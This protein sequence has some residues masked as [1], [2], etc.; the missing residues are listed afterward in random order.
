MTQIKSVIHASFPGAMPLID[1][2]EKSLLQEEPQAIAIASAFVSLPGF[3]EI[4]KIISLQSLKMKRII[5]GLSNGISHPTAIQMAIDTGWEVRLGKTPPKGI[6]HPKFILCGRSFKRSGEVNMPTFCYVGSSNLTNGGLRRNIE[7][8]QL[9][10]GA[11]ILPTATTAWSSIWK[12]ST[13]ANTSLLK[14]YSEYFSKRNR[15]RSLEDLEDLDLSHDSKF[16]IKNRIKTEKTKTK[17]STPSFS[18]S[19]ANVAWVGLNSFTGEYQFQVEFPRIVAEVA[20]RLIRGSSANKL[21]VHCPAD[22][23]IREMSYR[24]YED[25]GM[26]RLNIPND[27]PGVTQAR[28]KKSG[29]A[30]LERHERKSAQLSLWIIPPGAEADRIMKR[31]SMLGTW[32]STSTRYYGWY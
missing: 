11:T 31:S 5:I 23:V 1:L 27:V 6:F 2:L 14:K 30:V 24:F 28:D 3:E 13:P 20:K 15:E 25:N 7:C 9:S 4:E 21:K 18:P 8:G 17:K 22:G 32:E 29:L 16:Q 12:N 10:L 19:A 26:F